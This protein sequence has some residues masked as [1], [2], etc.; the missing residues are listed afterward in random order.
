VIRSLLLV[1]AAAAL[2][3]FASHLILQYCRLGEGYARLALFF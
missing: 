1:A 2:T 3:F